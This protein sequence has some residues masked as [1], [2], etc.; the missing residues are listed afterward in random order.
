MML[1]LYE[2]RRPVAARPRP[3]ARAVL[4]RP[5]ASPVWPPAR[6]ALLEDRV[7]KDGGLVV[8]K[9]D[10]V[11]RHVGADEGQRQRAQ[12][13]G[14]VARGQRPGICCA[15]K[16]IGWRS[17]ALTDDANDLLI[18]R[19]ARKALCRDDFAFFQFKVRTYEYP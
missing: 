16:H 9:N 11:P 14:I 6:L 4:V 18:K 17:A 5:S 1:K 12:E 13:D 2:L 3:S 10:G 15:C 7:D 19:G 8:L